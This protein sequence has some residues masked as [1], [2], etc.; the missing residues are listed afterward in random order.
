MKNLLIRIIGDTVTVHL[1]N[2]SSSPHPFKSPMPLHAREEL[3]WYLDDYPAQQAL[4]V[5]LERA[6]AVEA[7]LPEWGREIFGAAFATPAAA[8][9]YRAFLGAS[10][11]G[12]VVV[13]SRDFAVHAVPWELLHDPEHGF[14]ALLPDP[15]AIHRS[16]TI[17]DRAPGL[18]PP[19][20]LQHGPKC[21]LAV[22]ARPQDVA[23][24]DHRSD[25]RA[26]LAVVQGADGAKC[27]FLRPPTLSALR[28]RLANSSL[29]AVD[30][31]HFDGH[32]VF[33]ATRLKPTSFLLFEDAAGRVHR[34]GA[35][36]L[37]PLLA[38]YGA[39][40]VVL[41]SCHSAADAVE[42]PMGSVAA[43]LVQDG[44]PA[45]VAM[46]HSIAASTTRVLFQRFY[47]GV[48]R[49][50]SASASLGAARAA[51]ARSTASRSAEGLLEWFVPCLYTTEEAPPSDSR[52]EASASPPVGLEWD[53]GFV[54][55]E[56]ELYDVE[57]AF[58]AGVRR[59]VLHGFGGTGKTALSREAAR[60][61]IRTGMFAHAVEVD[62]GAP[63][64]RPPAE[65]VAEAAGRAWGA[66]VDG[67]S[68][69][70]GLRDHSTLLVLDGLDALD[71]E[72]LRTLEAAVT[73][74]SEIGGTR[75]LLLARDAS[76]VAR[77][78]EIPG[79]GSHASLRLG[80]LA[81]APALELF[82]RAW[83]PGTGGE[84]MLHAWQPVL[85]GYGFHP[86]CIL[87][88][89]GLARGGMTT[90]DEARIEAII[91]GMDAGPLRASVGLSFDRLP[92]PT[93]AWLPR[94]AA[95]RGGG[96]TI[97]V[98]DAC[99]IPEAEWPAVL[100]GLCRAGLAEVEEVRPFEGS[101]ALPYV[102]LHPALGAWLRARTEPGELAHME[103]EHRHACHAY[104]FWLVR[105]DREDP[106]W[107]RSMAERE[108]PNLR[109]ACEDTARLDDP[110]RACSFA[111]LLGQFLLK[112]GHMREAG[113]WFRRA[114]AVSES[115]VYQDRAR[116]S[117][118]DYL[119]ESGRPGEAAQ[120]YRS[121]ASSPH[122]SGLD[123][124]RL[125]LMTARALAAEGEWT[126][127]IQG[128]HEAK[129]AADRLWLR[130]H[131]A[132]GAL[133]A[134]RAEIFRRQGDRFDAGTYLTQAALSYRMVVYGEE[135][136]PGALESDRAAMRACR[137]ELERIERLRQRLDAPLRVLRES[138]ALRLP[139]PARPGQDAAWQALVVLFTPEWD[140]TVPPEFLGE[141]AE[142]EARFRAGSFDTAAEIFCRLAQSREIPLYA[143]ACARAREAHVRACQ[144]RTDDATRAVSDA[145]D[146]THRFKRVL[147]SYEVHIAAGLSSALL[148]QR[149]LRAAREAFERARCLARESGD[150]NL[151]DLVREREVR[152]A[153]GPR[154]MAEVKQGLYARIDVMRARH[155]PGGE[156]EARYELG[157]LEH[158]RGRYAEAERHF[159]AMIELI[160]EESDLS[161]TAEVYTY[162]GEIAAH[163]GR[164]ETADAWFTQALEAGMK[165]KHT[166][167]VPFTLTRY[168][169][170]LV[171]KTER[172]G[173]AEV[174]AH[175]ALELNTDL[176]IGGPEYAA[177]VWVLAMVA[178]RRGD[179]EEAARLESMA[180]EAVWSHGDWEARTASLLLNTVRPFLQ[181]GEDA[182]TEALLQMLA[183]TAGGLFPL[184]KMIIKGERSPDRLREQL[185]REVNARATGHSPSPL[186]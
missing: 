104:L 167:C 59:L 4:R 133:F 146:C 117:W 186:R 134:E 130:L 162:L 132:Q 79:G 10:P 7:R 111:V 178:R 120:V 118:A 172:V 155:S 114:L 52:H 58:A 185:V 103:H 63:C 183:S 35:E 150:Q 1:G 72:P 99:D 23:F 93:A 108:L 102:H 161:R 78:A 88:L 29:P 34:V 106:V 44:V 16:P 46:S 45:V 39:P 17:G 12:A 64:T 31:V 61:L 127:S 48:L 37:S 85:E 165:S 92:R 141:L 67:D 87:V 56:R 47:G 91:G 126:A 107:A 112:L 75:I 8:G 171:E 76:A 180:H 176:H 55:R 174:F 153:R 25:A 182:E 20:P 18:D 159:R 2:E 113:D 53:D 97:L 66:E 154:E 143:V 170:L 116:V 158:R 73:V 71:E 38:A 60:W 43:R 147:V 179:A 122:Q 9:L 156:A 24:I 129:A 94:F 33:D 80:G 168:A 13:E 27:E 109:V 83:E 105:E 157:R 149:E 124:C 30:V 82:R 77:A 137:E 135:N 49:G 138:V 181:A 184:M 173:D 40:L 96:G 166:A 123:Q 100:D 22:V 145:L 144:G 169:R 177:T 86:G 3:R 115:P 74:W 110:G 119:L 6:A 131:I 50:S 81:P 142:G 5:D 42:E 19:Q 95:L 148:H 128:Y 26:I 125:M 140:H 51:L 163:L 54:G 11:R 21:V 152:F 70:R 101:G 28:A 41:S 89:A 65:R 84:E 90:P 15:V 32:G 164:V 98:C 151:L 36:E 136:A 175:L 57:R 68:L 14:L 121:L 69:G 139:R 160:G 62:F